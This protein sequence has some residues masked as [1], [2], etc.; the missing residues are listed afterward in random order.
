MLSSFG[1]LSGIAMTDRAIALPMQ[2]ITAA[3][4]GWHPTIPIRSIMAP[5]AN[6]ALAV[7]L[8]SRHAEEPLSSGVCGSFALALLFRDGVEYTG[9]RA[10]NP[11]R[12]DCRLDTNLKFLSSE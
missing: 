2:S 6:W 5:F 1:N 9:H 4:S 12:C 3:G 10:V 11:R 7:K 8:E